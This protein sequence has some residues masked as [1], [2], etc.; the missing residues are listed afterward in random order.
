MAETVSIACKLPHGLIMQLQRFIEVREPTQTNPDRI[1]KVAEK[2]GPTHTIKGFA[3]GARDPDVTVIG[4]FAIN[5][6]VPAE[7]AQAWFEQ[8]AEHPAVAGGFVYLHRTAGGAAGY[9]REHAKKLSGF[10]PADPSALPQEFKDVETMDAKV[11]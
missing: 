6:G 4:N 1:V 5:N 8:N 3:N 2:F 10:E 11:A 9:A 7:F